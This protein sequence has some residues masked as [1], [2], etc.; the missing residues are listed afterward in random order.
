LVYLAEHPALALVEVL[1][2]MDGETDGR[3]VI[4]FSR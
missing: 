4:N 3:G 2:N 1:V